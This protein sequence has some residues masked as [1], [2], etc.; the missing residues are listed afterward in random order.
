M[1]KLFIK[2]QDLED[3]DSVKVF[4]ERGK[5]VYYT[6]DDFIAT[7]HRIKIFLAETINECAYV[8]EKV[9]RGGSYFEFAARDK[10]GTV[11]RDTMSRLQRY[12]IDYDEDWEVE[13]DG[14]SWRYVLD[15]G[16]LPLMTVRNESYL[17]PG[18][19]L[20]MCDTYI[21][22]FD[23]DSDVLIGLAFALA[24]YALNKYGDY[25]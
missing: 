23:S 11:E 1:A 17:I 16:S 15:R 8:Q 20:N 9:S 13:G 7:G 22:D 12:I 19:A 2:A 10:F 6:K 5:E 4:N 24:L 3:Y 25:F 21:M 18:Q 14:V